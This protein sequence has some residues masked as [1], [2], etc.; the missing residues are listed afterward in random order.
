MLKMKR[1][2]LTI[3]VVFH[4]FNSDSART[5]VLRLKHLSQFSAF[6]T[7]IFTSCLPE[8]SYPHNLITPRPL[9]A[10]AAEGTSGPLKMLAS[11]SA[12]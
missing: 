4:W 7:K 1:E 9:G 5:Q 2:F 3:Y 6:L 12:F 11:G 8:D 10:V